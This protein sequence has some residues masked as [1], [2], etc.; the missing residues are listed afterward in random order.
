VIGLFFFFIYSFFSPSFGSYG[1]LVSPQAR[2][3]FH[4]EYLEKWFNLSLI[5]PGQITLEARCSFAC[6]PRPHSTFSFPGGVVFF[7]KMCHR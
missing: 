5:K 4:R 7:K 1:N 3:T 6:R 2:T